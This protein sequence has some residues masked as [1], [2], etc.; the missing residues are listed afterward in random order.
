[1]QIKEL[2]RDQLP[3]I[4]HL[5]E[6]LNSHHRDL[7]TNFKEHYKF[8]TFEQRITTLLNKEFLSVIVAS[9]KD[10]YIAYCIASVD[11]HRGEIDSIYLRP[12]YR[13]QHIGNNLMLR[14]MEW[15]N[16]HDIKE[17][18][19]IVAEGNEQVFG[20]YEKFGFKKRFTVFQKI[21]I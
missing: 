8:F 2:N 14:A 1:M 9:D 15:L 5:W 11:K 4:K 13:G 21:M 20:F 19:I 7:S 12:E 17:I 3:E 16:K 6:E 10:K 18:D